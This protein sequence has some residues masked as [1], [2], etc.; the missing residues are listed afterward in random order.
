M[1]GAIAP[2]FDLAY[3]HLIDHGQVH[4][5]RYFTHWPITWLS[6]TVISAYAF[7]MSKRKGLA[8]P[9]LLF[10]LGGF[11]HML[12]DSLVGDIW[13]FAPFLDRP[14]SIA[15][16]AALYQPW[17]L[18]FVLHWSFAVELLICAWALML[19]RTRRLRP[20]P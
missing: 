6:L 19:Y 16:V 5:H 12:L 4:H 15:R 17:W 9:A 11:S 8:L 3:L 20:G 13:W 7:V 10:G 18:N 14:F 2:D 1:L